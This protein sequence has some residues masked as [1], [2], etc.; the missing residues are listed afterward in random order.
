M[1]R[2]NSTRSLIVSKLVA[3]AFSLIFLAV[4][5]KYI[6]G[7][8]LGT[9]L[10]CLFISSS[11]VFLSDQGI[12]PTLVTRQSNTTGS[13][14]DRA[15]VQHFVVVRTKR[16]VFIIPL[17]VFL[18]QLLT[19]ASV[20]SI[21]AVSISHIATLVY[22]TITAG[23]LGANRRYVEAISE[24]LSRLFAL[25][26]GAILLLG[27]DETRSAQ[28]V[29]IV[30]ALADSFMLL[31]VLALFFRIKWNSDHMKPHSTE[32][33]RSYRLQFSLTSGVSSTMGVGET[34]ALSIQSS[35]AD[36]AF[37]SL[38]ARVVDLSGLVASYAGYSHL[39]QL[40]GALSD[41][42]WGDLVSRCRRVIS[43][44]MFPTFFLIISILV[45]RELNL[46]LYG[47]SFDEDWLPLLLYTSS[48]PAV[49]TSK[50][51]ILTMQSVNP[52]ATMFVVLFVGTGL[53]I[54]VIWMYQIF[55][56]SGTFAVLSVVNFLR[57]FLMALLLRRTR[58][59]FI[60]VTTS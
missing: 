9:V 31:L 37:Y 54:S 49:V 32:I 13:E 52:K 1:T 8:Y 38:V 53:A 2:L 10:E 30:Y 44:S 17:L 47:F 29:L 12:T 45:A 21:I 55:G 24:P 56:L 59:K 36:Y 41:H 27:L 20:V 26:L 18:L 34:W 46:S 57:A 16:I 15:L 43:L 11:L 60:S 33:S 14:G 23:L 22:S 58:N 6:S 28:T 48:I 7:D 19:D 50:Y 25:L 35:P 39:P 42:D 4:L 40:I 51:L 5:A 3:S